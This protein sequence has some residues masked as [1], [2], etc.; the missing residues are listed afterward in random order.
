MTANQSALLVKNPN[1]KKA[2]AALKKYAKIEMQLKS[3]EKKAEAAKQTLKQAMIDGGVDKITFD[4][5]I[6]GVSGYITLAERINYKAT[7]LDE[8]D[9]NLKK[10]SLD[11]E[12]VKSHVTLTGEVPAGVE[13]SRTQYVTKKIELAK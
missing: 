2:I 13:V 5:E 12:K 6:T 8:V 9:D 3:A 1:T 10:Q 7:D 11:T 4:P